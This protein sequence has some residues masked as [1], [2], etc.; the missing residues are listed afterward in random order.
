MVRACMMASWAMVEKACACG[1]VGVGVG[2]GG[3][4]GGIKGGRGA[5]R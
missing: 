2:E 4:G 3:G 1:G 5:R